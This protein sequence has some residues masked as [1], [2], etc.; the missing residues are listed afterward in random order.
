MNENTSINAEVLGENFHK[1]FLNKTFLQ[2]FESVF[3]YIPMSITLA[4]TFLLLP[5][6]NNFSLDWYLY[7]QNTHETEDI[8]LTGSIA[9]GKAFDDKTPPEIYS[10]FQL[11][12]FIDAIS[13]PHG[14]AW[15]E[16][17]GHKEFPNIRFGYAVLS[18][19][20][21]TTAHKPFLK[22]NQFGYPEIFF[23]LGLHTEVLK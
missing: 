2:A 7:L 8:P 22:L 9:L 13:I 12:K 4:Q 11:E 18:F 3:D 1:T 19:L 23:N 10:I 17:K 20:V 21:D 14:G 16:L 6:M 5:G 15:Q